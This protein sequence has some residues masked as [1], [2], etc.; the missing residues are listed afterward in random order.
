M[1]FDELERI[2]NRIQAGTARRG[3]IA[4]YED[5]Y[6]DE[7]TAD[8]VCRDDTASNGNQGLARQYGAALQNGVLR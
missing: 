5:D 7:S 4:V 2:G 8:T 6:S 1:F 3:Y